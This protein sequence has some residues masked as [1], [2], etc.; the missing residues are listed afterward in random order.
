MSELKQ[1]LNIVPPSAWDTFS[2]A[3]KIESLEQLVS[4]MGEKFGLALEILANILCGAESPDDD[5]LEGKTTVAETIGLY[6]G[7]L[8]GSASETMQ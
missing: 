7:S 2:D 4:A 3:E 8:N 1:G 5:W 6:L